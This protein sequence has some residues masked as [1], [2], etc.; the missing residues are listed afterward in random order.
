MAESFTEEKSSFLLKKVLFTCSPLL[1]VDNFTAVLS[2]PK[3]VILFSPEL[4]IWSALHLSHHIHG[5][6]DN[7]RASSDSKTL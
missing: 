6:V 4:R 1:E 5:L 3:V 2:C 7:Q